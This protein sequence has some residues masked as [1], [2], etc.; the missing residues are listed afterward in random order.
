MGAVASNLVGSLVAMDNSLCK[1]GAAVPK[2]CAYPHA[3]L[4]RFRASEIAWTS[5]S[6]GLTWSESPEWRAECVPTG[7]RVCYAR[8]GRPGA[9]DAGAAMGIHDRDYYR[10]E[11]RGMFDSWGRQ[12]VTVWLIVVC[13]GVFLAQMFSGDFTVPRRMGLTTATM[14]D[15]QAVARGEVWRLLTPLFL[16]GGLFGLFFSMWTIYWAGTRLADRYGGRE[17]LLFFLTAGVIA[18]TGQFL[19]QFAG[20]IPD[21]KGLGPGPSIIAILVVFA[22]HY[23]REQIMLMMVIPI[24]VWL[25]AVLYVAFD[26]YANLGNR[27]PVS[28]YLGGAL[29]GLL[30]Y[31]RGWRLD[32]I[33]PTFRSQSHARSAPKLRVI[34]AEPEETPVGSVRPE[35]QGAPPEQPVDAQIEARVDR[36]LE[37]VSRLGQESL[38]SEE[39]EI[40]FRA[41]ELYKKRRK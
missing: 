24:P 17:F 12:G 2:V 40:L 39:R 29:F 21:S 14:Y 10:D 33:I 34:S 15:S 23:P 26:V 20:V 19:A 1:R 37:K 41:S 25:L 11:T 22:C 4:A 28:A 35:A 6:G 8:I 7:V 31:L 30:Y 9:T 16:N 18:Y 38:T 3:V 36:V 27:V 32:G 13:C 5:L